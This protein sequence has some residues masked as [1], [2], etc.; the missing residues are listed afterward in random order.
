M[1]LDPTATSALMSPSPKP[2]ALMVR[3]QGSELWDDRGKRYLD[4]TQ[5]WAVNSLGHCPEVVQ[6]ALQEQASTLINASPAY[7][8]ATSLAFAR[9]LTQRAQLDQAFLCSSGAEANE[10]A[11]KLARKWGALHKG[12]AFQIIT[13]IDSFHGRT[14]ATMAASGKPG[15]ADIFP[16]KMPGFVHVAYGDTTAVER[17]IGPDTVAVMVEPIQG[18]GG[19]VMPPAAYMTELR[20]L[21]HARGILLIADEIQTG[22]GRTGRMFACEHAGATG[23]R[24]DIMTL[25]KGIGAGLPLAAL[26]AKQSVCCFAPGDQGGTYTAHALQSAVG[27]AV[28]RELD[29][30]GFLTRVE[31]SGARLSRALQALSQRHDLGGVRG[32]GLLLALEL[33]RPT[34]P[35]LVTNAFERGLLIN[36]PRPDVLR[37]MPALNVTP[38]H[39]DECA[40]LLDDVLRSA[41]VRA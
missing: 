23:V 25:G 8:N 38:E 3:G 2:A 41:A 13:T 32:A 9:A 5:G 34:G 39:I 40:H 21:T 37:F 4:F 26:L 33:K 1:T 7:Y 10:G 24:P 28:L 16:P 11:I 18:E 35:A 36:S 19:V 12:G 14:L 15:F 27:L 31:R 29:S 17:A 6:R 22:M 20:A 30:P